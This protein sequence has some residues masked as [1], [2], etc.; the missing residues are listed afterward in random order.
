[1]FVALAPQAA[2][3][4]GQ[5]FPYL[6]RVAGSL[7]EAVGI[8]N[9]TPFISFGLGAVPLVFSALLYLVPLVRRRRLARTNEVIRA[10]GLARRIYARVLA[11]PSRVDPR[12]LQPSGSGM[13]PARF[14][15]VRKRTFDRFAGAEGCGAR[16]PARMG[17]SS[18]GSPTWSASR[19]TSDGT[20]PLS[21][22][23]NWR[24]GPRSSTRGHEACSGPSR[25]PG[26][27]ER[28]LDAATRPE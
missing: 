16:G 15:A 20:G 6:Y 12:E 3:R 13:D 19:P 23:R 18:T 24:R 9:P 22:S 11:D 10:E 1:M 14:E 5:N 17:G 26:G 2:A 27:P 21:I 4:I 25:C 28:G 7:L 8:A